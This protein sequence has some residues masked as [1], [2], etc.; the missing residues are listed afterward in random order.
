MQVEGLN[1]TLHTINFM[2]LLFLP[3][4]KLALYGY[5]NL[6]GLL[7]IVFGFDLNITYKSHSETLCVI[8]NFFHSMTK[9]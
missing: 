5:L 4:V 1:A 7:Y 2:G 3:G 8:D 9:V 6:I